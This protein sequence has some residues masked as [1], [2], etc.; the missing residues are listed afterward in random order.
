MGEK[1]VVRHC[2][3]RREEL[4]KIWAV[5]G[6]NQNPGKERLPA[7]CANKNPVTSH[8][9]CRLLQNSSAALS[10]PMGGGRRGKSNKI[11]VRNY[12]K[13]QKRVYVLQ[14]CLYLY[15]CVSIL[16]RS[17]F[18]VKMKESAL[19]RDA[20]NRLRDLFLYLDLFMF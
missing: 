18:G 1:V 15:E 19:Y 14:I 6:E 8:C 2:R 4:G 11:K 16:V 9:R 17:F 12:G 3:E 7:A 13:I 10:S 5:A 20:I